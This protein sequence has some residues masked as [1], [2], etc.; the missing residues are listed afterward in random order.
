VSLGFQLQSIFD[1]FFSPL[2]AFENSFCKSKCAAIMKLIALALACCM[3]A[4][5]AYA[6]SPMDYNVDAPK[7]HQNL[8]DHTLY[9]IKSTCGRGEGL[10]ADLTT[11][12]QNVVNWVVHKN[13]TANQYVI[14]SN[15]IAQPDPSDQGKIKL[16]DKAIAIIPIFSLK[17]G[18]VTANFGAC[19]K[20][21]YVQSTQRIYLIPTVAWSAKYT[22]GAAL[23][24]LYEATKLISPLWSLFNPD[25]LAAINWEMIIPSIGSAGFMSIMPE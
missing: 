20:S 9:E 12:L 13:E 4:T 17:D 24:A 8:K 1:F 21:T 5:C 7:P 3:G 10:S 22:E 15:D 2:F 14:I 19:Q 18:G 6:K 11:V 25:W 16:P 23:T